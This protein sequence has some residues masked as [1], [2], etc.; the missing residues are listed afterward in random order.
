MTDL[1]GMPIIFVWEESSPRTLVER[2]PIIYDAQS[3]AERGRV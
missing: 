1:R 2:G 3:K